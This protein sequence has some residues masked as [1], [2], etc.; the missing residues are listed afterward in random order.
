LLN[1]ER[2]CQLLSTPV[3]LDEAAAALAVRDPA[4]TLVWT[5]TDGIAYFRGGA[6]PALARLGGF[7]TIGSDDTLF[8]LCHCRAGWGLGLAAAI[9]TTAAA[10]FRA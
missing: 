5:L 3:E 1:V 2:H 8:V 6:A 4:Y 10:R 7:R 9:A